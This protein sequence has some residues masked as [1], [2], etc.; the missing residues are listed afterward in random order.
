MIMQFRWM[1]KAKNDP[2]IASESFALALAKWA[3]GTERSMEKLPVEV[4]GHTER[5]SCHRC[6]A[7][8]IVY[9]QDG[10]R[11]PC[12]VCYGVGYRVVRYFDD[13]DRT[14]PLCG[15]MGR[16]EDFE[17]GEVGTC[18]RCDGRGLIHRQAPADTH[19]TP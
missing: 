3:A 18:P 1:Q 8:G 7:S 9:T 16:A 19:T 2:S 13:N 15:G 17:T 4:E 10:Q 5:I 11:V 6:E 12:P 14:C